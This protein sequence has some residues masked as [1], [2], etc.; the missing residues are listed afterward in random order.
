MRVT[1]CELPHE[2]GCAHRRV[3]GLVRAHRGAR[4]AAGAAAR[5]RDG[6]AGV[7]GGAVRR[8]AL[9]RRRGPEAKHL[10]R[11][12]DLRAEYVVGTRPVTREWAPLESGISLVGR[13]RPGAAA[14]TSSSCPRSR[15]TGRRR[16]SSRATR[17]SRCSTPAGVVRPQ[18]LHRAV[19]AGDVWQPTPRSGVELLLSPRATALAT[20]KKWLAV[21]VVAAVR[22]GAF[23]LSSNRVDPTGGCG[24]GG[25]IIDPAGEILAI[26]SAAEPFATREIDLAEAAAAKGS[27]PR[28]VF[29]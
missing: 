4:V 29:G 20:T 17:R 26:T 7:G 3:G 16:G 2:T 13:R 21:G 1:V 12:P 5:V 15:G 24:G 11:L 28:Y 8:R 22:S 9:E 23:S 18:H 19:G 6:G 14:A 27:Y 10:R 25:W